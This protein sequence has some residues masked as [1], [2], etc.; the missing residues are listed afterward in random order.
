MRCRPAQAQAKL[1]AGKKQRRKSGEGAAAAQHSAEDLQLA[2]VLHLLH[3]LANEEGAAA[4]QV[5]F[6]L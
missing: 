6:N 5:R 3:L 4:S 2:G 1:A